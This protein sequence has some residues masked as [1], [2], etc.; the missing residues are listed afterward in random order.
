MAVHP[1]TEAGTPVVLGKARS[2]AWPMGRCGTCIGDTR[3][4]DPVWEIV[5]V[6]QPCSRMLLKY[7]GGLSE[8][9]EADREGD[10]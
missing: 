9:Q 4:R 1:G 6:T 2:L 8:E 5:E 3:E 10:S 7:Q